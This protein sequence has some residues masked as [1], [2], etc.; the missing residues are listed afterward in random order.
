MG[1][2]FPYV[3]FDCFGPG[4]VAAFCG[5]RLDNSSGQVWFFPQKKQEIG[6]IHVKYD[7]E[8]I[9]VKRIKDI[10]RAGLDRWNGS[11]IMGMPDLG[12][13]LDVAASLCDS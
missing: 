3:N 4:V 10:Y 12:G 5:A 8:N 1:D 6:D 9:W 2:G 13:V 7:P 11:V